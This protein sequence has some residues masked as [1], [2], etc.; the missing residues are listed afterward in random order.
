VLP[1]S[2][3][4]ALN[5]Y[6]DRG[7]NS[8]SLDW[9]LAHVKPWTTDIASHLATVLDVEDRREH[10]AS[11]CTSTSRYSCTK[12]QPPSREEAWQAYCRHSVY[13]YF[14]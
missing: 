7:G 1:R 11:W 14:L 5:S 3:A 4:P 9:Q 6:L 10:K 8:G 2:I 13:G 12:M